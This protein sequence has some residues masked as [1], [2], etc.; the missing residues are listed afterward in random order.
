MKQTKIWVWLA[1]MIL[2]TAVVVLI[3]ANEASRASGAGIQPFVQKT[4]EQASDQ[5]VQ[6]A[7]KGES[8]TGRVVDEPRDAKGDPKWIDIDASPC[9]GTQVHRF[10]KP[11][12]KDPE[13]S[14]KC[15]GKDFE[16]AHVVKK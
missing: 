2:L 3:V 4:A 7:E 5:R 14:V 8:T 12:K 15:Q 10:V 9:D 6:Y 16:R 11:Y 1:T 13:L